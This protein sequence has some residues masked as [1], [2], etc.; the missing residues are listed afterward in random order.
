MIVAPG[1]RGVEVAVPDAAAVVAGGGFLG[2]VAACRDGEALGDHGGAEVDSVDAANGE[3]TIILVDIFGAAIGGAGGK[4]LGH[5]VASGATTGPGP[6]IGGGAA[7]RQ[8]GGVEAEQANAILAQVET[9][10]IADT[11]Q[12]GDRWRG[13]IQR[14]GHDSDDGQNRYGED[15][16]KRAAK[17]GIAP[18][19]SLQDFTTR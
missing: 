8:F 12:A 10:A 11:G 7:L 19:S 3:E 9:V 4:Q 1:A 5:A 14:R 6:A 16:P 15:R 13:Q 2:P 18:A 17:D